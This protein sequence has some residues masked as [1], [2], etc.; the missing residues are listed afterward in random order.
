MLSK[1]EQTRI[2][3]LKTKQISLIEDKVRKAVD[4]SMSENSEMLHTSV[5]IL[6][7]L[8][9]GY[10]NDILQPQRDIACNPVDEKNIAMLTIW[11]VTDEQIEFLKEGKVIRLKN[12]CVKNAL[13]DNILQVSAYPKKTSIESLSSPW[14]VKDLRSIGYTPREYQSI[15]R[16][17]DISKKT[18]TYIKLEEQDCTGYLLK[19]QFCDQNKLAIYITDESGLLLRIEREDCN[20]SD[21]LMRQWTTVSH[22][23]GGK[24]VISFRDIRVFPFDELENCAVGCWTQSTSISQSESKRSTIV[25]NWANTQNSVLI[26]DKLLSY[27]E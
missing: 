21:L 6:R 18:K 26:S 25:N 9:K 19:T 22:E 20:D 11:N 24:K 12:L 7:I 2:D 10:S 4:M 17:N 1:E 23:S 14:L 16:M 3:R 15:S 13:I 27:L 8:V 5:R